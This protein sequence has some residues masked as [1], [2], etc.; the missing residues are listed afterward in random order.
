[1]KLSID[2]NNLLVIENQNIEASKEYNYNVG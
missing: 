2:Q 1:M